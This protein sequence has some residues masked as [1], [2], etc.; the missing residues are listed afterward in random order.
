MYHFFVEPEWIRDGY[1]VITGEDV[2]HIRNVLRMHPGEQIG[3]RDGISRSYLC[4]LEKIGEDEVWARILEDETDSSELPARLYLFQALPK[5]DKMDFII[6]KAVE[7]G[8]FQIIPMATR[9]CVVKLEGKKAEN[10]VQRWNAIARSAAKQSGRMVIPEVTGILTMAE[11]IALAGTM[12]VRLIPYE[13]ATGMEESRSAFDAVSPGTSAAI[14][15]GPEGG[16]DAGEIDAA[17]K[18]GIRP[19]TLGRRILRTETAGMAALSIL[20]FRLEA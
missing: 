14:F 16:F 1:A 6:Q 17:V 4:A 19:V 3:V 10:K 8:V 2:N 20:M 13:L 18:A 9:R 11:A 5:G 12:D 7:L 15:I